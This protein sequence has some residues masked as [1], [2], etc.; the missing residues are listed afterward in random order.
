MLSSEED[1]VLSLELDEDEMRTTKRRG[2]GRPGTSNHC[3][4]RLHLFPF[5]AT[6]YPLLPPLP[7]P[8][9]F[10]ATDIKMVKMCLAMTSTSTLKAAGDTVRIKV[11]KLQHHRAKHSKIMSGREVIAIMF[12]VQ[13]QR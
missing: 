6:G 13:R 5:G 3:H 9:E 1:E 11:E 12:Q 10:R 8:K 4:Q 7:E 2:L